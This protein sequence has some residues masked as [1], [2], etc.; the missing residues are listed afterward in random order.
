MSHT[1]RTF[2]LAGAAGV[3][4]AA[5]TRTKAS[6]AERVRHAVI[7]TGGQGREHIRRFDA[8]EDCQV[9]AVCDIDP[10]HREHAAKEIQHSPAPK[11]YEDFR[12][13]LERES[14]DSVSVATPD[15]WH[16][17]VALHALAA[18]KHVYIEKP[19]CHNIREGEALVEAARKM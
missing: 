14:I 15:H 17:P 1:R 2:L 4:A 19:C 6:A 16:V 10:A 3:A 12:E 5:M 13:L 9:V 18:G 11:Q 8:N 7:G